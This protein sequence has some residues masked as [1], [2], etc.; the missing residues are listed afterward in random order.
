[1]RSCTTPGLVSENGVGAVGRT[2]ENAPLMIDRVE[3]EPPCSGCGTTMP[4]GALA[5]VSTDACDLYCFSCVT[6][7]Y[8]AM[9]AACGAGS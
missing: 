2:F 5:L 8:E 3:L 1:M 4:P 9:K 7:A 6:M